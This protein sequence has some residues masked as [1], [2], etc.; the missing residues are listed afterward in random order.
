MSP[1]ETYRAASR[2]TWR[3]SEIKASARHITPVPEEKVRKASKPPCSYI[4]NTNTF[5]GDRAFPAQAH[6]GQGNRFSAD[7]AAPKRSRS[8]HPSIKSAG[9]TEERRHSLPHKP[10]IF[11]LRNAVEAEQ[12]GAR[13]VS[14]QRHPSDSGAS[15]KSSLTRARLKAPLPPLP[16]SGTPTDQRFKHSIDRHQQQS[17]RHDGVEN[18]QTQPDEPSSDHHGRTIDTTV[19]ERWA[20]AVTHATMTTNTHEITRRTC[21]QRDTQLPRR[22][23]GPACRRLRNTSATTFH[24]RRRRDQRD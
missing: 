12:F 7:D 8:I 4:T 5:D 9:A 11:D 20:P 10:N 21:A 2:Y 6:C 22:T 16:C 19:H 14:L 1:I 13:I 23:H 3:A 18:S 24:S 15:R 17:Q